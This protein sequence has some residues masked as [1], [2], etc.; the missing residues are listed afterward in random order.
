MTPAV[1]LSPLALWRQAR[2]DAGNPRRA[3][4]FLLEYLALRLWCLVINCFPIELNLHTARLL[5]RVWWSVMKR[6]RERALDNLRPALGTHYSEQQLREIARRSFEHFTQV[7]LVEL[8]M[9]PRLVTEWSWARYVEL[10]PIGPALRELLG[11]RGVI[12]LTA[13]F[14]NFELLGYTIA[15]LGLPLTAIMRPL[16]NTLLNDFLVRTRRGSGLSLLFKK[17]AMQAA[18]DILAA[19][20]ALCFIADQDAGRKGV[21]ADFFHRPASWYKSIGLLAMRH[22]TPIIVGHAVRVRAGFR[23]RMGID[24]IIQP[25]EWDAASDP[26]E[27]ITRTF[28]AAMESAIRCYPEQYLWVHR[29]W[30]TRPRDLRRATPDFSMPPECTSTAPP[31]VR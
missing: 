9:T 13:H 21:F 4:L 31:Q 11:R 15:R 22:R 20:G 26:L 23:Y 16:D 29:R 27:W 24:R 19:G 3:A 5:G 18:D 14:G 12:L 10:G 25:H 8:P 28:A 2:R 30:K 6:H 1:R 17:G 7:Y